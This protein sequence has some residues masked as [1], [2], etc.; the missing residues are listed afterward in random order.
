MS[1]E[2]SHSAS[3]ESLAAMRENDAHT[4]G[5]N[6][7]VPGAGSVHAHSPAAHEAGAKPHTKPAENERALITAEEERSHRLDRGADNNRGAG[8]GLRGDSGTR[9]Q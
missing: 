9:G 7:A 1:K 2:H 6:D 5:E 3:K 4:T 8:A